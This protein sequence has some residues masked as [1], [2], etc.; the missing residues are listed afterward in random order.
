MT[1]IMFDVNKSLA[2]CPPEIYYSQLGT[3]GKPL[4]SGIHFV[5]RI[6]LNRSRGEM[7]I[8]TFRLEDQIREAD[9]G[10]D[11]VDVVQASYKNV[12]FLYSKIPQAIIVDPNNPKRFIGVVGF[13]RDEAQENLGWETAIYDIIEYD[14]PIDLEAFKVN[15]NDDEDHVPAF[16]NTKSTLIKSVVNAVGKVIKDD[17]DAILAYLGR[18]ARSKPKW[19]EPILT[20]IRKEHISR[21]PTMKAFSAARAKEEAIRLNLPYEGK[22]NKKTTSLG[23]ARKFR[24]WKTYFWDGF[25]TSKEYGF[26][27][28]YLTTWVDEPNPQSLPTN[29]KKIKDDFDKMEKEFAIWV[30][31]Y[32]A[33]LNRA[34]LFQYWLILSKKSAAS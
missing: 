7:G 8:V 23:Y 13:G 1:K 26:V 12:G 20:T 16:P 18:I 28:V 6:V 10:E 4:F 11:R 27:K 22:K 5:K 24:N 2:E 3:D 25:T 19:H 31:N 29:R 33:V 14:K 34:E 9:A 21:W 30:S 17:D 15:S 32:I